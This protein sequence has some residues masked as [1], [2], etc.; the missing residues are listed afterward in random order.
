MMR[1]FRILGCGSSGG[2]PR[3]H[4]DWGICDPAQPKNYRSRCSLLIRQKRGD[5]ETAVL[6]DTSPDMRQQLLAAQ[7]GWLDA[8]FFTHDHADQ[9]HGIDDVRAIVYKYKKRIETYMDERTMT[10][11][12]KRFDYCFKQISGSAYPSILNANLIAPPYKDIIITGEGGAIGLC[13]FELQHGQITALGFRCGDIAYTPDVNNIPDNAFPALEN[14]DCWIIDALQREPH[15]T[16]LHLDKALSY[17]KE[18][19]PKRA[20]LTNMHIDM[21]YDSLCKELPPHI[22]PAYDGLEFQI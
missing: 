11:L 20:I 4:G 3:I 22:I 8:V 19:K 16:H 17:I 1:Q 13:P 10:T 9:S 12:T 6:I 21:D 2:V 14:L 15:P 7:A 5:K 18:V